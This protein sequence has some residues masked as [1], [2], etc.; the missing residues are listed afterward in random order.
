MRGSDTVSGP[1]DPLFRQ[2]AEMVVDKQRAST[3]DVQRNFEIG[4]NRAGRI[5]DQ[6]ER[7][8]IVSEQKGSR[9]RDVLV[10]DMHTLN[11][12]LAE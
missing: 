8:G 7:A 4:F 11:R 9:P 10:P 12:M 3:S 5:M 2:V 1:N 6:L